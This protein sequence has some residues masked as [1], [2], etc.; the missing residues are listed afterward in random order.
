MFYDTPSIPA[1]Y[2]SIIPFLV[3]DV[4]VIALR[5]MARRRLGQRLQADDWI[6]VPAFLGAIGLSTMYFYGL[7]SKALGYRYALLPPPGVDPLS[8]D[9]VP[10]YTAPESR[11]VATRRVRLPG[12]VYWL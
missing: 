10:E 7:G 5:F 6:M 1:L 9:Y 12:L 3:L 8:E 2:G 11:I 4:V